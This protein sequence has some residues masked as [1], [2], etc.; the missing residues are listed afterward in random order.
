MFKS[1]VDPSRGLLLLGFGSL[2]NHG[3]GGANVAYR[4]TVAGLV[5]AAYRGRHLP[6][7]FYA[8]RPIAAGEELLIDYGDA[9]ETPPGD[10][11]ICGELAQFV[12][13]PR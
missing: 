4:H 7:E 11:T 1:T 9:M 8:T 12:G 3:G 10:Y 5:A 2:F 6:V 13:H